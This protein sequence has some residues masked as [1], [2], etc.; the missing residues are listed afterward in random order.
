[1]SISR[2]FLDI[3]DVFEVELERKDGKLVV[4]YWHGSNRDIGHIALYGNPDVFLKDHEGRR[5]IE[6]AEVEA[7]AKPEYE[8][9]TGPETRARVI[10]LLSNTRNGYTVEQL[11]T[12][13]PS[14]TTKSSM[15]TVL[16]DLRKL[17][18]D[19]QKGPSPYGGRARAFWIAS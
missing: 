2:V 4:W 16:H 5:D 17:G 15:W 3:E 8:A 6:D 18:V 14:I 1:M 13:V 19:I 9:K 10:E 7:E 12:F 11:V